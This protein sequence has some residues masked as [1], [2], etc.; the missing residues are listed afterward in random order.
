MKGVHRMSDQTMKKDNGKPR[1]DLLPLQC[2]EGMVKVLTFGAAKY[3]DDGWKKLMVDDE[4][5]QRVVASA[6]RHQLAIERDGILA[7]DLNA[8]GEID[9]DHSGLPHIDHL[10]CCVMFIKYYQLYLAGEL[11]HTPNGTLVI[12]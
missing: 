4:G 5:Y 3:E 11:S 1:W 7:L 6:R 2:I 8:T 12:D 9:E 10:Q